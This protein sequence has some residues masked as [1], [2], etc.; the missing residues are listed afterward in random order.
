MIKAL[1][2][3]S[4]RALLSVADGI[5]GIVRRLLDPVSV[6]RAPMHPVE[7]ML[8][9]SL[10]SLAICALWIVITWRAGW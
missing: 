9:G 5:N 7:W 2:F 3:L 4:A 8:L 10:L 1:R 6:P